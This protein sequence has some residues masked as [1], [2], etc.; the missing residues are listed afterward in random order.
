MYWG[1]ARGQSAD[2]SSHHSAQDTQ[3][4]VHPGVQNVTAYGHACAADDRYSRTDAPSV[5]N[6]F[7]HSVSGIIGSGG[8]PSADRDGRTGIPYPYAD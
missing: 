4:N 7:S 3:A 6:S 1:K 8:D 5:I 2:T